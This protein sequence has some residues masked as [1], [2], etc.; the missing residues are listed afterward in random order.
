[1]AV[2]AGLACQAIVRQDRA[3]ANGCRAKTPWRCPG[4]VCLGALKVR[5][6]SLADICSA[7]RRACFTPKADIS[8]VSLLERRRSKLLAAL[9]GRPNRLV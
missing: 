2:L 3:P 7:K 1:M 4:N 6:G 5:F 8:R 9:Y